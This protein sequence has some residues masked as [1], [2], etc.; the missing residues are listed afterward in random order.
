MSRLILHIGLPKSGSTAI[1]QFL[2]ANQ[3][4]LR[5]FGLAWCQSLRGPNHVQLAVACST[6]INHLSRTVGVHNERDRAALRTRVAKRLEQELDN[7]D[8][9]LVSTEHLSSSLTTPDDVARL[10]SL[11]AGLTDDVLVVA[12][13]RRGDYWLPSSYSEAVL[14]NKEFDL[15]AEFVHLREP[16][17]DHHAL[18]ARWQGSFGADAVRLV[19]MLESDKA[20]PSAVPFRVLDC[21]GVTPDAD[22]AW[23]SPPK[24]AHATLSALGTEMLRTITPRL[25]RGGLRPGR[26]RQKVRASIAARFPGAGIALTPAAAAELDRLGW[27][28]NGIDAVPSAVGD[29]WTAWRDQPDADVRPLP[30]VSEAA[31]DELLLHLQEA[32]ITA[33]QGA[34]L[35]DHLRRVAKRFARR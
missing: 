31:V 15:D 19:P 21:V 20:D 11:L 23:Q 24:T 28:R 14:N 34:G 22:T 30:T 5:E 6:Q 10:A 9:V 1:Q 26:Y 35:D 16:L 17:L 3:S 27:R 13:L 33:R 29:K 8:T 25:P 18:L 12:V 7:H 2:S 32:G 4:V